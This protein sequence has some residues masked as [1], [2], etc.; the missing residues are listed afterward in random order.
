MIDP[1]S[2]KEIYFPNE[3]QSFIQAYF[4]DSGHGM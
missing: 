1:D 3:W 4:N 2:R